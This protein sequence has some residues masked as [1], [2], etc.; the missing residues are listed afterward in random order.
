[1]S[2]FLGIFPDK[3]PSNKIGE[4]VNDIESVFEGFEI[5]VRWVKPENYHITILHFGE[6]L[7]FY[8]KMF[9]KQ[10]LKNFKLKNFK[11]KFNTVKLGISRRYKEL[12]YL[13]LSEGGDEMR[14]LFLE[15]KEILKTKNE[16]NF[17]PHLTLGRVSKDLTN[18][19]Y[20]NICRDLQIVTKDLG[21]GDIEFV[22]EDI[23]LVKSTEGNYEFLMS[24]KDSSKTKS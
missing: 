18:Q 23:K 2:F 10:R 6:E 5:P 20:S 22:V 19:E 8:K 9:F 7:P 13:D 16:G 4:V 17:T 21:I 24:F 1:M 15:L 3:E 12:I 14:K 11:V